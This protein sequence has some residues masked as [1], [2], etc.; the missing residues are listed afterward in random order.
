M[1]A[2]PSASDRGVAFVSRYRIAARRRRSPDRDRRIRAALTLSSRTPRVDRRPAREA[3]RSQRAKPG[4]RHAA[5][6]HRPVAASAGHQSGAHAAQR[7]RTRMR[8]RREQRRD[9]D[10][11]AAR[12]PRRDPSARSCAG[13]VRISGRA[14]ARC[15]ERP[16]APSAR[17]ATACTRRPGEQQHQPPSPR[18]A[19]HA[20][21][22]A[23]GGRRRQA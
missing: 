15:G 11:V 12:A 6:Q 7:H 9:E 5:E 10:Q 1:W 23:R 19:P 21:R 18:H 3:H 13:A 20:L 22:T 8:A 14:A 4:A 17:Q 16:C 2:P